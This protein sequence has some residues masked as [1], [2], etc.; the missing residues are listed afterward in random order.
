M[1]LMLLLSIVQEEASSTVSVATTTASLLSPTGLPHSTTEAHATRYTQYLHRH[2]D[3]TPTKVTHSN[4][5]GNTSIIVVNGTSV[6]AFSSS[7]LE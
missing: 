3:S 7:S 5:A 1:T 4:Y 2:G 6:A